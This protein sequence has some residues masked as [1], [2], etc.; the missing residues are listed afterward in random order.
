ME[1]ENEVVEMGRVGRISEL[2]LLTVSRAARLMSVDK[3]EILHAMDVYVESNG[4]D[5]LPFLVR[6]CRRSIRAGAI[7][8]YLVHQERKVL[9]E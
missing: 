7:R 3:S 2:A 5:G 1:A 8:E 6:G 9:F 4:R